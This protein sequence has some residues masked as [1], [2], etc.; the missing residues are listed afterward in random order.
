MGEGQGAGEPGY[1]PLPFIP[2]RQGR[3]HLMLAVK[4]DIHLTF[5]L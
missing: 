1:F 5:E 3:G 4:F 2:S